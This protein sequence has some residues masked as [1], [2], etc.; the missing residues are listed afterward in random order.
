MLAFGLG[1]ELSPTDSLAL[2]D[3]VRIV[4]EENYSMKSMIH[5]VVSSKPFL[6]TD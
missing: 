1:R 5:A 4:K 2:D 3:I 6:G